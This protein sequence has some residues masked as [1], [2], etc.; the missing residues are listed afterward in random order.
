MYVSVKNGAQGDAHQLSFEI[1]SRIKVIVR[2]LPDLL[3]FTEKR[4]CSRESRVL[5][6]SCNQPFAGRKG[7]ESY[8][9]IV[10]VLPDGMYDLAWLTAS[11]SIPGNA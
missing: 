5:I 6:P 11:P 4:T 2:R 10:N 8:E 3:D 1:P 7:M 9:V